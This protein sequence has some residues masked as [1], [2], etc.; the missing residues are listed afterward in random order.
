MIDPEIIKA[1]RERIAGRVAFCGDDLTYV[2]AKPGNETRHM[3]ACKV[4]CPVLIELLDVYAAA[5]AYERDMGTSSF[6]YSETVLLRTVR[7]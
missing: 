4:P 2:D 6:G 1:L 3:S 5:V 7:R